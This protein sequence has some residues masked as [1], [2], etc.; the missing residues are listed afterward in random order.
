MR[1]SARCGARE[2][3]APGQMSIARG[4]PTI[5]VSSRTRPPPGGGGGGSPVVP[6]A[7][8]PAVS[9]TGSPAVSGAGSP[10]VPALAGGRSGSAPGRDLPRLLEVPVV[11]DLDPLDGADRRD[12]D[13]PATVGVL[14]EAVL[15]VELRVAS[16]YRLEGVGE[17]VRGRRLDQREAD[18]LARRGRV[19]ERLV[20]LVEQ[21]LVGE[22]DLH[23]LLA[24][25][26]DVVE[27]DD[28]V[29]RAAC[30]EERL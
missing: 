5:R 16:P 25:L 29:G 2:A 15:V 18:V 6:G 23:L 9:G 24:E 1:R 13:A 20:D 26:L 27:R 11:V 10:V 28:D 7:G 22:M 30:V 19:V 21:S 12:A 17:L 8:S 14:L 4:V 3:I